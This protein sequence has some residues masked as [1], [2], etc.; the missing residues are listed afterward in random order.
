R[1]ERRLAHHVH[2]QPGQE[3]RAD[4]AL[5][6]GSGRR[7]PRSVARAG[8]SRRRRRADALARAVRHQGAASR[9]RHMSE[10]SMAQHDAPG[11]G[12]EEGF[13]D[14]DDFRI[15]YMVS[16]DGAPLVHLHGA[17]GLRLTP[18]HDLLS[19]RFRVI[20][21]EMPGFGQSAENTRTRTMPE[22]AG[23]M[24]RATEKLGIESFNL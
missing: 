18:A 15:R 17:G 2:R 6:R 24:A 11:A 16:G 21:F 5:S 1:A 4:P 13:V 22:L 9:P 3:R 10:R 14:A 23:T 20:A 19:R 8:W 12:F 7:L